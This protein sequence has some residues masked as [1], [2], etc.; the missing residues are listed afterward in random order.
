M[1][2]VK[3]MQFIVRKQRSNPSISSHDNVFRRI[4]DVG[5]GEGAW[6]CRPPPQIL[7][8]HLTLFKPWGQIMLTI[9][10]LPPSPASFLGLPTSLLA[11]STLWSFNTSI[12]FLSLTVHCLGH[13]HKSSLFPETIRM[14]VRSSNFGRKSL[15]TNIFHITDFEFYLSHSEYCQLCTRAKGD[16]Q[17]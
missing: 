8:N 1:H 6:G 13:L 11:N 10:F 9:V 12:G 16:G 14:L 3:I 5:T 17:I 7:A 15:S 4:R 2:H